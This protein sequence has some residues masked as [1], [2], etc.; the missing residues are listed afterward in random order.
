VWD[1][2][3]QGADARVFDNAT[4][5]PTCA[6]D[7]NGADHDDDGREPELQDLMLWPCQAL[8]TLQAN[9]YKRRDHD[10]REHQH[11]YRLQAA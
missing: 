8:Y 7:D 5:D 6:L 11:A 10:D 3:L 4:P 2:D 9:L 1:G